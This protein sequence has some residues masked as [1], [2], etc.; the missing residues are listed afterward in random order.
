M[1]R[2]V[3]VRGVTETV[4]LQIDREELLD[5]MDEHFEVAQSLFAYVAGQREQLNNLSTA[6]S[7]SI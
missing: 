6:A 4:I 2:R 7:G 5:R 1:P 3:S